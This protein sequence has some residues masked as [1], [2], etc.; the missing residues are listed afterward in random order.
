MTTVKILKSESSVISEGLAEWFMEHSFSDI[1]GDKLN[2]NLHIETDSPVVCFH[3]AYLCGEKKQIQSFGNYIE[4]LKLENK[5]AELKE[6]I[7]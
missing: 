6:P 7:S 2:I 5:A 4:K 1:P 3:L